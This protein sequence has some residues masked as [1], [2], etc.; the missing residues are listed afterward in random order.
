MNPFK[1][2]GTITLSDGSTHPYAFGPNQ[3]AILCRLRGW[4]FWEQ[5]E[6]LLP[7]LYAVAHFSQVSVQGTADPAVLQEAADAARKCLFSDPTFVQ[8]F[9]YSALAFGA[10]LAG[11]ALLLT[12]AQVGMWQQQEPAAFLPAL[13]HYAQLQADRVAVANARPTSAPRAGETKSS[14][15]KKTA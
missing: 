14:K 9:Y 1:H 5:E 7:A 11:E 13:T 8:D 12:P 3:S 2:T 15:T 6:Q 10:E 4:Q